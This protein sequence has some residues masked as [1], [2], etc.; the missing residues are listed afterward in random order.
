MKD[1]FITA[2]SI[3]E[4]SNSEDTPTSYSKPSYPTAS[5]Q[6]PLL[7]DSTILIG[8]AVPHESSQRHFYDD[9]VYSV[10]IR[11]SS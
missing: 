3:A 9:A 2:L 1:S 4:V 8:S 11:E 7:I 5:P 10:R 6:T